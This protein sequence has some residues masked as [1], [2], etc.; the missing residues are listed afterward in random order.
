[1]DCFD[2]SDELGCANISLSAGEIYNLTSPGYPSNYDNNL[3]LVWTIL[4]PSDYRIIIYATDIS[5]EL[6]YDFLYIGEGLTFDLNNLLM[7]FTGSNDRSLQVLLPGNKAFISFTSDYSTTRQGFFLEISTSDQPTGDC[8]NSLMSCNS[9]DVCISASAF[10][11]SLSDCLNEDDEINCD[12]SCPSDGLQTI[13]ASTPLSIISDNY[14]IAYSNL[15]KCLWLLQAEVDH[16]LVIDILDFTLESGYD[17]LYIGLGHNR[18]DENSVVLELTGSVTPTRYY[19]G[20][21]TYLYFVTDSTRTR[22]GFS[23][24]VTSIPFELTESCDVDQRVPIGSDCDGVIDCFD[25]SDELGCGKF[26]IPTLRFWLMY[27]YG[28]DIVFIRFGGRWVK[29]LTHE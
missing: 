24:N 12:A 21:E 29:G 8:G 4:A 26:K 11:D 2:N 15:I 6:N 27:A 20:M 22:S 17:Y 3:N 9:S 14:P 5:T 19:L 16:S 28:N 25:N 23:M 1:M 13:P 18:L 10:C 7:E